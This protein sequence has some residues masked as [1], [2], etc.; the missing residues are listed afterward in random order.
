MKTGPKRGVSASVLDMIGRRFGRWTVENYYGRSD[1]GSGTLFSCVCD[2]GTK[3][4]V[5]GYYLRGGRSTSCGCYQREVVKK[6]RTH[7]YT[8]GGKI[9]KTYT[10][11][12]GM[13]SRCYLPHARE[14][15]WYGGKG[16]KVCARWSEFE[17]FLSDMGEAPED[18]TLDRINGDG[19]YEPE[20]CRWATWEVQLANR[21]F[22]K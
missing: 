19:N 10:A 5:N 16:I 13:F 9:K 6:P 8:V 22:N 1:T 17:N 2:C 3:R 12:Q 21:R 20:N 4:N 7:G 14:Y 15:R 18:M 11:W